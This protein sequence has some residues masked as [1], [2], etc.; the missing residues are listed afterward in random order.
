MPQKILKP[1]KSLPI[2]VQH[3][4]DD[5][6]LLKQDDHC[7]RLSR[8]W[9]ELKRLK[10]RTQIIDLATGLK[11]WCKGGRSSWS[12]IDQRLKFGEQEKHMVL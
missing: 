4:K 7:E 8:S 5:Q 1:S 10:A 6:V 3:L 2:K 12:R 9:P 11:Y